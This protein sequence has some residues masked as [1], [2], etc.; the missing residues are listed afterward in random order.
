MRFKRRVRSQQEINRIVSQYV[1]STKTVAK[2]K[3][4]HKLSGSDLYRMITKAGVRRRE[5]TTV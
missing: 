3:T 1:S 5:Y 4:T 2:L